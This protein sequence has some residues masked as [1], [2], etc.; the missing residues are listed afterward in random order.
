[1]FEN[2]R[3]AFREAIDN[4]NKELSRDQVPESVDKL[5]LGMRDEVADAKARMGELES[6]IAKALAESEREK[7]AAET[8]RRR[9]GMARKIED[10]ETAEVAARYATKHEERQRLLE[11]KSLAL[12]Q[13]LD[14]LEREYE[15]MLEKFKDAKAKR[16]A[17]AAT[18]GRSGARSSMQEADDLFAELDRMAAKIGGEESRAEAAQAFDELDLHVDVD[19]PPPPPPDIDYDARLEELKRRMGEE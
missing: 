9:E 18:A 10:T 8:A 7:K 2:L 6:Q 11:Q 13:E 5:L 17:L 12:K 3:D 15:E 4:F 16:E 14:F 19:S 1:M